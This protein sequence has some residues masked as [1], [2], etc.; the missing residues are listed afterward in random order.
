[1]RH[2]IL[3]FDMA[4]RYIFEFGGRGTGPMWFNF[5]TAIDVDRQGRVVIAD[6]FNNR[7][8]ILESDFTISYPVFGNTKGMQ[9]KL[10]GGSENEPK[11][12]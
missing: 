12:P 4:G 6:L 9:P 2:T 3:V 11:Q 8:Q 5:P 1:M 10:K 7:I